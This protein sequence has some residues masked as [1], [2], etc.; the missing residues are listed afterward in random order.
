MQNKSLLTNVKSQMLGHLFNR[1][2]GPSYH[3]KVTALQG[4]SNSE[5]SELPWLQSMMS[6]YVF[7]M[8]TTFQCMMAGIHLDVLLYHKVCIFLTEVWQTRSA[9][10]ISDYL[11]MLLLL[12]K[13]YFRCFTPVEETMQ[14]IWTECSELH[15]LNVRTNISRM[16]P[17]LG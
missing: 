5:L 15:N 13:K 4:S 14:D 17:G 9:W 12:P 3:S 10:N 1:Q 7:I 16:D 6:S 8:L 11:I 2:F